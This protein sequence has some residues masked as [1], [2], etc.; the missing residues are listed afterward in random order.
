MKSS[1]SLVFTGD[2]G[3]DKYME[4]RWQDPDLIDSEILSFL[5]SSDHVIANVEGPIA[6]IPLNTA[7]EGAAQL[8]H[9]IDPG[10]VS[11]LN[12]MH[13]DI[14]NICNNHI[15][16]AG[17]D[18]VKETLSVAAKNKVL[19]IGAGMDLNEASRPLILDEADGI[20]L[21]SVGYRRGCKPADTDKAGCFLWNET[22]LI[23]ERINEVK[24]K[25]RWCI[26]VS[27]GGEE[28][29][30]LPSPYTRD[31]YL[32]FLT[33][34][35]D[36]VV[37]HHPHVPMN[38]EKV[39]DKYIFYS[40]GNF[41]FDTPYQRAQYYTERGIV[42]K[43]NVSED[44]ISFE[45]LGIKID[46]ESERVVSTDLP[47]IFTDVPAEEYKLLAPLSAKAFVA[48]TKRQQIFMKNMSENATDKEWEEHFAN[49]KRSGRVEGE[50]LDFFII[51]PLA[52]ETEKGDW[53]KSKLEAV[54]EY[55][56]N[57]M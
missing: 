46:R 3:F 15:M 56:L 54:K 52:A 18:G 55:I 16:D 24:S 4:G 6:S 21:I 50:G 23:Q 35:A 14:W 49:P 40:L 33:M 28:F 45:A 39:G 22:E 57:S 41:I 53:R 9:T 48:A 42:L 25:C 32:N 47:D 29:T 38:Y 8:L 44:S 30:A 17:P 2:I 11:V 34:G 36:A 7:T 27:H 51:C 19:T 20:G 5:H 12:S 26:I 10:A 31:R 1:T 43:L 37:S 13:A